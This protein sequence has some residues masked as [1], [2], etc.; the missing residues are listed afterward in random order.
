MQAW[1]G[2]QNLARN[3]LVQ[4]RV[5]RRRTEADDCCHDTDDGIFCRTIENELEI[6]EQNAVRHNV[7]Q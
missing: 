4:N 6:V 5:K 2:K 1:P 3:E 7:G